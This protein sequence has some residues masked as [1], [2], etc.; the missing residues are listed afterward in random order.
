MK[1]T[2]HQTRVTSRQRPLRDDIFYATLKSLPAGCNTSEI[3]GICVNHGIEMSLG[4]LA[5]FDPFSLLVA[6][7]VLIRKYSAKTIV[8]AG[9]T[10]HI[11]AIQT[12]DAEYRAKGWCIYMRARER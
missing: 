4:R 5:R 6:H 10:S 2:A 11:Q 9:R 7:V 3:W 8:R 1:I 12:E